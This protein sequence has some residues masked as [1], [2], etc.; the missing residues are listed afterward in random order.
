MQS[1][2]WS[3][4]TTG[5]GGAEAGTLPR[6][7]TAADTHLAEAGHLL[8]DTLFDADTARRLAEL[9]DSSPIGTV[10]DVVIV[11]ES[12]CDGAVALPFELLRLPTPNGRVLATMIGPG[13]GTSRGGLRCQSVAFGW[14]VPA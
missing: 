6:Q 10:V 1:N 9:V 7:P 12:D 11:G 13:P 14:P 8:R 3:N 5:L 4:A 2:V